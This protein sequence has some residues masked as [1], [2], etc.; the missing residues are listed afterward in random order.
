M[1]KNIVV[2]LQYKNQIYLKGN[3]QFTI[4]DLAEI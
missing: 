4:Y 3:L 2:I 1:V